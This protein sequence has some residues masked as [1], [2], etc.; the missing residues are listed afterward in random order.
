MTAENIPAVYSGKTT[1][2]FGPEPDVEA[3]CDEIYWRADV[4][5][6]EI[7]NGV[8]IL[9]TEHESAIFVGTER[10]FGREGLREDELGVIS[11]AD[12]VWREIGQESLRE[13]IK[14]KVRFEGRE[15]AEKCGCCGKK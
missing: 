8:A 1:L 9:D 6:S 2:F 5:C 4:R 13:E 11:V 3:G 14:K 10:F 7:A 12:R 15:E